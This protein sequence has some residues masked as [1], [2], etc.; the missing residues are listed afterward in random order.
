MNEPIFLAA[1]DKGVARAQPGPDESWTVERHLESLRIT[2]LAPDASNPRRVYA[3][4][5]QEGVWRSDD[6][7]VTWQEAGLKG[8]EI[9]SLAVSPHDPAILFAGTKGA[10]MFRSTDG[11][12]NW[13]E[14]EAFRKVPNRWWWF[15]PAEPPDFRPYVISIA[16][17]PTDPQVVLAGIEFGAVVRSED[18]GETW[19][20]HRRGALRDCHSLQFHHTNGNWAYQAGGTGGRFLQPERGAKLAKGRAGP[21]EEI[22]DRLRGGRGK[23]GGLVRLRGFQPAECF[24]SGPQRLSLPVERGRR[25]GADRLADPPAAGDSDRPRDN[26]GPGRPPVRRVERWGHLAQHEL[27]RYLAP[28]AFEHGRDL[29]FSDRP[30]AGVRIHLDRH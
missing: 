14:L 26:P 9:K 7:G 12:A 18:G 28:A 13:A 4:A 22:R 17:S 21:G 11:G 10:L 24:R 20:R 30:A 27:R 1:Y 3:G 5:A 25:L 15:S 19:S 16:T 23:S 8:H 29:V 2:C 6:C